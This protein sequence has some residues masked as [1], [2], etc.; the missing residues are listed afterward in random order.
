MNAEP[1]D[2]PARVLLRGARPLGAAPLDVLLESGRV[3][4]V[5][6]NASTSAARVVECGGLIALPGLVDLH[7]H[8]RQPGRE[9]A[10]TVATGT[11]AAAAGGYTAV[12]AMA[13]TQPVADS[14]EVVERVIELAERSGRC[15]VHP[16]GA[17]TVGLQG[18]QLA[19][20]AG[21][22]SSRAHVTMFSD[23][24]KCVADPLVMR[25]ALRAVR[26]VGGVLA[27]HAEEPSLTSGAQLND[28]D[29]SRE[30]GLPGWPAAA[31][32][33]IIARDCVLAFHERARVHVCHVSTAESVEVVRWAK[34][35]CYPITAEV[36]PHHLI[37]TDELARTG[38]AR[39][40][41]NPPLR[42]ADDVAALRA[43]LADGTIDAVATDHAPHPPE[44]KAR[45][46]S[47]APMG[48]LGL[49]TALAVV[50]ETMVSSGAL[51]WAG[52]ADRMAARPARIGGLPDLRREPFGA[53]NRVSFC[54]VDPC[55]PWIVE[56]E[57][58]ASVSRNTPFAGHRFAA[59]VIATVLRGRVTHD[60]VGLFG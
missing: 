35:R 27:Q 5:G 45:D 59:R 31:E 51:T 40:K 9:F 10:E 57:E 48:M 60:R 28:G 37:L 38:D 43:G 14:P 41:V 50:A 13:N 44:D 3:L 8:L 7:T 55:A 2:L 6:A 23:D 34:A 29:V 36:T 39:Y 4:A 11:A 49:E 46:W 26:D 12:F 18:R 53:G 54:L 47:A 16:V 52:L 24:G 15:D 19:D 21:L 42:T 56:S 20:I 32:E 22:A 30:L 1:H 25:N 33:V 58:L 17:V